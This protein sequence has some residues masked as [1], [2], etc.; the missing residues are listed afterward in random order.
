MFFIYNPR[1]FFQAVGRGFD[2]RLPLHSHEIPQRFA[3][4]NPDSIPSRELPGSGW[5]AAKPLTKI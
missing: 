4:R 2:P 5:R 1:T 3:R